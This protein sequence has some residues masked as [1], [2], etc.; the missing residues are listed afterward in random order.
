MSSTRKKPKGKKQK[1][2]KFSQNDK[3][4]KC[5]KYSKI[6]LTNLNDQD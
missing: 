2:S 4:N 1:K 5:I 6:D 3:I